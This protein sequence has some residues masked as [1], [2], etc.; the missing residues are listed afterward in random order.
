MGWGGAARGKTVLKRLPDFGQGVGVGFNYT[1][2]IDV[3]TAFFIEEHAGAAFF[4][5]EEVQ[6]TP[7]L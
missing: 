2:L 3:V 1:C 5:G 7:I 6:G 4:R